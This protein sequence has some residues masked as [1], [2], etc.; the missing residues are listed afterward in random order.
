M[1]RLKK[2]G[3]V[4]RL[5]AAE[6]ESSRLGIGFE[7]LDRGLFD[8]S[9]AYDK[10]AAIGVKW[11]RLQS[12]WMRTE[13]ERGVYSFE[14]LDEI[15]DNL[16]ARGMIPWIT[17]CYGNP[18]YTERAKTA[19][20]A[21]GCPPI[22]TEDARNGWLRYVDAVVRHFAGRVTW[23]EVWNEPDLAYSWKHDHFEG[24][25]D[26]GPD[27]AEY[28]AFAAATADAVHAADAQAKVI[29][30]SLSGKADFF[31]AVLRNGLCDHVDALSYH[32]YKADEN[33]H[34]G[35][36]RLYR[37]ITDEF[38]PSLP[39]IQGESG[40]QSSS[41]GAGAMHGFAWTPARQ[42]KWLLRNLIPD[43][44]AGVMF[45]SYFSS[46]DM[47]EALRGTVGDKQSYLD[48]GYFGV[49]GADF[50]AD[51]IASGDYTPKPSYTA[52][53]TLAS[54]F[55]GDPRAEQLPILR[56]TE[57]SRR[58]N[59]TDCTDTSVLTYGFRLDDGKRALAYWNA[60]PLLSSTY[61]GTISFEVFG[62]PCEN[63]TLTDLA[64][65][66]IYALPEQMVIRHADTDTV[67]VNLPLTDSPLLL[68]FC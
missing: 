53:C 66:N 48:Y 61:E 23:Y 30:M 19:F 63:L 11:I 52:L 12:G 46:L 34:S 25:K 57:P 33:T 47:V 40:A 68:T 60:V 58:L 38:R 39:L 5:S 55:R 44:A 50:D 26:Y 10:I 31:Y 35:V 28:A 16:R 54:I 15:V 6:V 9:K 64:T 45:T 22:E 36:G 56:R 17:L 7:K 18:L 24:E 43:L 8:P 4:P 37:A 13:R 32:S 27:A 59:G 51:G 29:G 20:G 67:L 49:L 1:E 14:W 2:I 41:T 21:V 42:T 65:G 3:V 62:L